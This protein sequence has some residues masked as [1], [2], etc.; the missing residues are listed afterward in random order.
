MPVCFL[1]E[2]AGVEMRRVWRHSP[3][4]DGGS[5]ILSSEEIETARSRIS[6][7]YGNGVFGHN[8]PSADLLDAIRSEPTAT[9]GFVCRIDRAK[10]RTSISGLRGQQSALDS[11]LN[12]RVY[13]RREIMQQGIQIGQVARQAGVTV[14]TIRFYE[15]QRLLGPSRRTEGGFRLFAPED[16]QNIRFI[17]RA[18][19]LGFSL[20]EIRELI[21]LQGE[22]V[23][24]C[25]HVRD[26]LTTKLGAV[27]HKIS[28]LR[29][30]E[31]H[32]VTDLKECERVLQI[33]S[34]N[35][36]TCPVLGFL[37]KPAPRRRR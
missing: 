6:E 2:S 9:D 15:K 31:R 19:E 26:M 37:A 23:E 34:E 16:L 7:F 22:R 10:C 21:I 18:Q 28:E 20:T 17:R 11:G 4:V 1:C 13:P 8:M 35:H 25:S 14:D 3:I 29:K 32:L 12:S 27:R 30:L 24:A 36:K 33:R 5:Q